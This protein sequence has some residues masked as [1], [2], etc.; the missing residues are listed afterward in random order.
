MPFFSGRVSAVIVDNGQGFYVLKVVL[1]GQGP[2][3]EGVGDVEGFREPVKV[4]GSIYGLD[5]QV[6]SWIGFEGKWTNHPEYGRQISISRAPVIPEWT[7]EIALSILV[8]SGVPEVVMRRILSRTGDRMVEVLDGGVQALV[9]AVPDL[10]QETCDLVVTRWVKTQTYLRTLT[11]MTEAGVSRHKIQRVWS[12]FDDDAERVL[13]TDPWAL[14]KIDGITFGQA[15]EISRKLSLS[16]ENPKRIDGAVLSVVK[17][18]RG[19]GHLYLTST[20]VVGAVSILI[21]Q[22]PPREVARAIA[23]L[24]RSRSLVVDRATRPGTVAVYEPWMHEVEVASAQHLSTRNRTARLDPA[25][26]P[27]R[28]YATALSRIGDSAGQA[29]VH[30]PN[31][32]HALAAGAVDDWAHA[33]KF[34]LAEKQRAGVINALTEPVSILTGLP[35]TGKS[36]SLRAVVSILRDAEV[37]FLIIAPTGI[38]AKKVSS[39][40]GAPASTIHRAFGAKG[41]AAKDREAGYSGVTGSS[42]APDVSGDSGEVWDCSQNAHP[43]QVVL[44]DETSM[45]DQHLLYRILTCTR[46]D[47]R[48]VFIGDPAQLPSVGPGNVLSDLVA[49]GLFPTVSLT[50]IFRQADTSGIVIA[51]HAIHAGRVPEV[52]PTEKKSDFSF[53]EVKSDEQALDI[54]VRLAERLYTERQNFQVLSPRHVGTVGVTELNMRLRES[55]NPRQPGLEEIKLGSEVIREDDRVMVVKND[56]DMDVYNGDVGKVTKINRRDR[57]VEVKIHGPPIVHA[58]ISVKE[59]AEYL[60]LAYCVTVHKSQGLE[61]DVIVMPL[62]TGFGHQLQRNLLYTAITRARRRVIL[63]GQREALARAVHNARTDERNT[64]FLERLRR[65]MECG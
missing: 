8:S 38:A 61:Y 41:R 46:P 3:I 9:A 40:T 29:Y 34:A 42:A 26:D 6:N 15:D 49:S 25:T 11:L 47:A 4:R 63:V 10:E 12:T 56:Y 39:V 20:E 33:A 18:R 30:D 1:D 45:V 22:I 36:T 35:G 19:L 16:P 52:A 64:L 23:D 43:A 54:V 57:T 31:D 62:V 60:R 7:P 5:I 55:L 27:V 65:A 21:D 53:I 14:V 59:A 13:T 58:D 48:I 32:L 2:E 51:A 50:E 44:I 37:P 17:N 24:H 28:R